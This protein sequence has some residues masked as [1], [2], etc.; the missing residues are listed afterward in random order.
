MDD[1]ARHPGKEADHEKHAESQDK[2]EVVRVPSEEGEDG[3]D[4]EDHTD[5]QPDQDLTPVLPQGLIPGLSLVLQARDGRHSLQ[6]SGE[7]APEGARVIQGGSRS[8]S[9]LVE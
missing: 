5:A 7:A 9:H 2:T 4:G 1:H 6:G 8:Y 3:A